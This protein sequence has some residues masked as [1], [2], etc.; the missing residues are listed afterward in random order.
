MKRSLVLAMLAFLGGCA[1][2]PNEIARHVDVP[3]RWSARTT[4][5][6]PHAPERADDALPRDDWWRELAD[7]LLESLLGQA[8]E[9]NLELQI[10][11]VRIVEARAARHIAA[12][13]LAP[14]ATGNVRIGRRN[15]EP[16]GREQAT[17]L[18]EATF[19]AQWEL[20]LFG[21]SSAR[22]DA[23]L[24]DVQVAEYAREDILLSLRAEVARNYIDLRNAQQRLHLARETLTA[25]R[26]LADLVESLRAA[27][28]RTEL[29]AAQARS[30]VLSL[31]A[32]LPALETAVVTTIRR[33]ETLLGHTPGRLDATLTAPGLVPVAKRPVL[34]DQPTRVLA[35]RPDVQRAERQFAAAA[36][37]H[38][39]AVSDMYPK[40]SIAALFGL[41]D[42]SGNASLGIGALS[43]G[44][45]APLFNAGRLRAQTEA[46]QARTEQAHIAHELAMLRALEDVEVNVVA[47][48]NADRSLHMQ[49]RRVE[50]ESLRLVLAQSRY[51][52]GIAP[53]SEVLDAQRDLYAAQVDRSNAR[54]EAARVYVALAKSIGG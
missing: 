46:A 35:R 11:R 7:P 47:Y 53:F 29:D 39:A 34:L 24:A 50:G 41:R 51:A 15:T 37:L 19:D 20:D 17:S 32:R 54:A 42:S 13:A 16:L 18:F 43:G 3:D 2:T 26:T 6:G 9:R 10:A 28:L 44:M 21:A 36:S 52:Q 1:S 48:F 45:L 25:S 12:S 23:A 8:A 38:R 22:S 33:I 31:D 40:I 14:S 27:G 30:L 49:D 5:A 4:G